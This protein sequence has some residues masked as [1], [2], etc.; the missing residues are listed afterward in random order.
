MDASS[1]IGGQA[2]TNPKPSESE[3]AALVC[4]WLEAHGWEVYTEVLHREYR[5]DI[6]A[7]MGDTALVVECK[8]RACMEV[9]D[10]AHGWI[11]HAD[12]IAVAIP[13]FIR[14]KNHALR[15]KKERHEDHWKKLCQAYGLGFLLT[16]IAYDWEGTRQEKCDLIIAP[17]WQKR[18]FTQGRDMIRNSL[19]QEQRLGGEYEAGTNGKYFTVFKRTSR[20]AVEFVVSNPGCSARQ[21]AEGID[22][23]WSN[24]KTG[25]ACL[26]SWF[27][28]SNLFEGRIRWEMNERNR[29]HFYPLRPKVPG[30]ISL[31]DLAGRS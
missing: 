9:V 29:Y 11:G 6:V 17:D 10:Q 8:A 20:L 22:H 4:V 27:T 16:T 5:A 21:I 25:A 3:Y 31:E 7:V 12:L 30:P 14:P 1:L 26:R 19:H 24:D 2:L 23:H 13:P 18:A 28:N 15:R